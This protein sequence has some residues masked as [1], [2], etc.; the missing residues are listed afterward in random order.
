M[1]L[2]SDANQLLSF[3]EMLIAF[4]NLFISTIVALNFG[5]DEG[6]S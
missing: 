3:R 1:I 4:S 6:P 2:D 5:F